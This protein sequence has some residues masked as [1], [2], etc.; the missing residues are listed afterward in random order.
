MIIV[1]FIQ[2]RP[3]LLPLFYTELGQSFEDLNLD[4]AGNLPWPPR[5]SKHPFWQD[6]MRHPG[7][8]QVV[9]TGI[10]KSRPY[11]GSWA[12]GSA[13]LGSN[14]SNGEKPGRTKLTKNA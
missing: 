9:M 5:G 4:H 8:V 14:G 3:N 13:S 2:L 7:S 10:A 11:S 1:E 6:T 12:R